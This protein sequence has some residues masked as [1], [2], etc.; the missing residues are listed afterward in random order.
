MRDS[1][2]GGALTEVTF[3]IL[4][5]L[6]E[7]RHGYAVMQF[8]AERTGGRLELGAGTLYGALGTLEKR[9]WIRACG[10]GARR[11]EYVITPDG[12][13]AARAELERLRTLAAT[14]EEILEGVNCN[15]E[16]PV[17]R[18]DAEGAGEVAEQ[19][20]APGLATC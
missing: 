12:L 3:Y 14:A 18:A 19:D 6:C 11:L 7:P 20:G 4:L 13:A 8:A 9:G 17:L 1:A 10:G 15:G 16:I 2:G 5:A